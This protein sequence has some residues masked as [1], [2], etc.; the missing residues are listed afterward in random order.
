MSPN[1]T[2]ILLKMP[3]RKY[4]QSVHL[5]PKEIFSIRTVASRGLVSGSF[6]LLVDRSKYGKGST[7][8]DA[9]AANATAE[10]L[11]QVLAKILNASI[12]VS[13]SVVDTQE[14]ILGR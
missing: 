3:R 1:I 12:I 5:P 7:L 6:V 4:K 13:R 9:V 8:S 10:E 11:K 14:G 2:G